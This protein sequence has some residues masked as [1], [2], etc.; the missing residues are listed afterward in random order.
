MVDELTHR[1]AVAMALSSGHGSASTGLRGRAPIASDVAAPYIGG[2]A[3]VAA[4]FDGDH[5]CARV[6]RAGGNNSGG[7]VD[8]D[9]AMLVG[10]PFTCDAAAWRWMD[11]M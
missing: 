7:A 4:L 2:T 8:T 3:G 9:A 11:T 10:V 1:V 5:G 6:P